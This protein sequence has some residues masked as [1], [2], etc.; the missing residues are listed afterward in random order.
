MLSSPFTSQ[1]ISPPLL[2]HVRISAVRIIELMLYIQVNNFLIMSNNF[3]R[4]APIRTWVD[5]AAN[6]VK[7]CNQLTLFTHAVYQFQDA[8]IE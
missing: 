1:I 5:I 2:I 3:S 6:V 8:A 4:C 7:M